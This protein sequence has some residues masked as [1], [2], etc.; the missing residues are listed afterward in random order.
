MK[1]YFSQ[2]EKQKTLKNVGRYDH[3][4]FSCVS[5]G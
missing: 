4:Y 1:V 2:I 3:Q 5:N